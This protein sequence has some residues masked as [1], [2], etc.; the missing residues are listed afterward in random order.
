MKGK[1]SPF[2]V[3]AKVAVATSK[4]VAVTSIVPVA[5]SHIEK[6]EGSVNSGIALAFI[7]NDLTAKHVVALSTILAYIVC[8]GD[9]VFS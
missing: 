6:F 7:V 8:T 4:L 3:H 9:T 1:T 2:L 5:A